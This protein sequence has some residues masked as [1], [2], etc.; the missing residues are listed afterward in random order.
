MVSC[1]VQLSNGAVTQVVDVAHACEQQSAVEQWSVVWQWAVYNGVPRRVVRVPCF[2]CASKNG[3]V[4]ELGV[5]VQVDDIKLHLRGMSFD[6]G[7]KN[8]GLIRVVQAMRILLTTSC[9]SKNKFG[10]P[11]PHSRQRLQCFCDEQELGIVS[12]VGP[13][14]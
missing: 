5:R 4:R 13:I 11:R 10:A 1:G 8:G 14:L 3:E 9:L 6:L 2:F 7:K 12:G